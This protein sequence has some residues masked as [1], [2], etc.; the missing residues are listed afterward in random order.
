MII[1]IIIIIIGQDCGHRRNQTY[2]VFCC[3]AALFIYLVKIVT[4]EGTVW[5]TR[6]AP[7]D[8]R[9]RSPGDPLCNNTAPGAAA[10]AKTIARLASTCDMTFSDDGHKSVSSKSK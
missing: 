4:G 10:T 6:P 2:C 7:R 1:I 9:A 5:E 8:P 3:L